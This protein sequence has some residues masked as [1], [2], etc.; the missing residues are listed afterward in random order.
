MWPQMH[1]VNFPVVCYTHVQ[2]VQ[3]I[4]S[5]VSD[6]LQP[7]G[8]QYTRLP[9]PSPT[10]RAFS[11]SCRCRWWCYPTIS[12]S[13]VS[14][15]CLQSFPASGSF[16]RSQFFA[17]GGQSIGWSTF[18]PTSDKLSYNCPN[19]PSPNY[20]DL[21]SQTHFHKAQFQSWYYWIRLFCDL[22][23]SYQSNRKS[24][25]LCWKAIFHLH[26]LTWQGRHFHF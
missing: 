13:V 7:H 12:S 2:P 11:N 25:L 4:C 20:V 3:F 1:P 21:R 5:V 9:C 6:S 15:S 17:S 18:Q 22:T 14:S 26:M 19:W 24:P 8:L 10:P 23:I 16:P